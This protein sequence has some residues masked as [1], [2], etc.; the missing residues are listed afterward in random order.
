MLLLREKNHKSLVW[1]FHRFVETS[2][3][4]D[5][6]CALSVPMFTKAVASRFL[7]FCHV[8]NLGSRF[9]KYCGVPLV[10]VAK[11]APVELGVELSC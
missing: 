1:H 5:K 11:T 6:G 7:P 8:V 4:D 3:C 9:R 2:L 10:C